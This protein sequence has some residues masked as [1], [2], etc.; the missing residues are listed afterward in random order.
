MNLEGSEHMRVYLAWMA[1]IVAVGVLFN[2]GLLTFDYIGFD[3]GKILVGQV[4]RLF[5]H[6]FFCGRLDLDLILVVASTFGTIGSAEKELFQ[7]RKASF[8]FMIL[9][10][11]VLIDFALWLRDQPNGGFWLIRSVEYVLCKLR[12]NLQVTVWFLRVQLRWLPFV[13]IGLGVAM[14]NRIVDLIIPCV[15][16]HIVFYVLYVL[17]VALRRPVLK[18]PGWMERLCEGL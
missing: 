18:V 7:G 3:P 12:P 17:P 15:I 9:V 1:S 16:G 2:M 14:G 13:V 8:V 4:W 5:S 10:T 6:F 11:A